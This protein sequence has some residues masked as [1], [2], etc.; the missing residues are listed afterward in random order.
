MILPDISCI[1]NMQQFYKI[2]SDKDRQSASWMTK[3]IIHNKPYI[4][5]FL[6]Y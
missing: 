5:L 1:Y 4:I 3:S 6:T 2:M